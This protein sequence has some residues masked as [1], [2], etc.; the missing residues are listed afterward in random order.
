VLSWERGRPGRSDF[1]SE[2][3]PSRPR[4]QEAGS[5]WLAVTGGQI[6]R[7]KK[8]RSD[9]LTGQPVNR[10][11]KRVDTARS[12]VRPLQPFL[13][14]HPVCPYTMEVSRFTSPTEVHAMTTVLRV[15]VPAIAIA[16]V[17]ALLPGTPS[18]AQPSRD[19]QFKAIATKA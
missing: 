10:A 5:T 13:T 14:R 3:R 7:Y 4:S 8:R 11:G 2:A 18:Q 1:A 19:D 15:L 12:L 16:A 6:A 17:F 9:G